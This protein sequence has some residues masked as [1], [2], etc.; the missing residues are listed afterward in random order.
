MRPAAALSLL[1]RCSAAVRLLLCGCS[2]AALLLLCCLLLLA[3]ALLLLCCL[4]LL[5]AA[6]LLLLCCCSVAALAAMACGTWHGVVSPLCQW[7]PVRSAMVLV[8]E[9]SGSRGQYLELVVWHC[10]IEPFTLEV[11]WWVPV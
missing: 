10:G 8:L 6:A 7:S 5:L 3:A 11:L 4:L 2:A 1:C 9:A